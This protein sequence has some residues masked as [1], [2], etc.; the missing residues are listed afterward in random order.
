MKISAIIIIFTLIGLAIAQEFRKK[1]ADEAEK[2]TIDFKSLTTN[3]NARDELP[4]RSKGKYNNNDTDYDGI[5]L[6]L[7]TYY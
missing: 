2:L 5:I 4:K 1:N 6:F 3:S 7:Y